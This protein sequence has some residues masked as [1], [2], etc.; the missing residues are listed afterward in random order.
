MVVRMRSTS[1]KGK[2]RRSQQKIK[3]CA[4][5]NEEGV[6]RAMHRASRETGKYKGREVLKTKTKT[7][8]EENK[9]TQETAELESPVEK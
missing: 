6:P 2:S 8:E 9:T 5:K 7:T 4:I 3:A 1:G